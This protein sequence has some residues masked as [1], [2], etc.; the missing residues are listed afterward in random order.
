MD[1]KEQIEVVSFECI[2]VGKYYRYILKTI[3]DGEP[4]QA[5]LQTEE[6]C[7]TLD[8]FLEKAKDG[9]IKERYR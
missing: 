3:I 6:C 2:E 5:N 1:R 7:L 9:I 8:E 4:I